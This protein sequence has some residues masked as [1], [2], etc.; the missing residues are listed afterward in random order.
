MI[1]P[2]PEHPTWQI[3]DSTKLKE[4]ASCRRAYFFQYVLGWRPSGSNIHLVFGSAWHEA[5]EQLLQTGYGEES[6]MLAYQRLETYYRGHFPANLDEVNFPKTPGRALEALVGYCETYKHDQQ[7]VLYTEIAGTVPITETKKLHFRQDSILRLDDGIISRE[8]KTGSQLSRMWRDQW[9]MSFQVGTYLHVLYCYYPPEEVRGVQINGVI[10][11]KTKTQYERV[12]VYRSPASMQN[13]FWMVK[14][15]M[16][17]LDYEFERLTTCTDSDPILYAFPQN[18]ESCTKYFGCPYRDYCAAWVN[19]LQHLEQVPLDFKV[20]FWDPTER[21]ANVHLELPA[22]TKQ[23][24]E[25]AGPDVGDGP[26]WD[27]DGA[28]Q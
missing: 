28:I 5:M 14:D 22:P 19:P 8:H 7:E 13:W 3:T 21:E 12:P 10:F 11:N 9:E 17:L 15:L 27:L 2:V 26:D 1:Y 6:L 16:N 25:A 24:F 18:P 23:E 4:F 20:E